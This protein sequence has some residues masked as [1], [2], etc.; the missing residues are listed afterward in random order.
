MKLSLPQDYCDLIRCPFIEKIKESN[1]DIHKIIKSNKKNIKKF[2][3][4]RNS[5]SHK[6]LL[7]P[8]I[9]E[10]DKDRYITKDPRKN[11]L[12]LGKLGKQNQIK[13]EKFI[14]FYSNMIIKLIKD[15]LEVV[16]R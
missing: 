6:F 4:Y 11:F 15:I 10:I 7:Y 12:E 3:D 16:F 2:K 5:I 14:N 9:S 1:I 8:A 13:V